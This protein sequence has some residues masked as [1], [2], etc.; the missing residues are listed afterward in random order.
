MWNALHAGARRGGFDRLVVAADDRVATVDALRSAEAA[1]GP[2]AP[3]VATRGQGRAS[4][5]VAACLFGVDLASVARFAPNLAALFDDAVDRAPGD[6]LV[7]RMI[8]ARGQ[9]G[10]RAP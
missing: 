7:A 10:T 9:N 8:A 5:A 2:A 3:L 4:R 1:L 6:H